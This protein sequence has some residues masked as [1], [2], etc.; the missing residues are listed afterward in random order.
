MVVFSEA[1]P[2]VEGPGWV[3]VHLRFLNDYMYDGSDDER[4]RAERRGGER[5]E[6]QRA[7]RLRTND[8]GERGERDE[9]GNTEGGRRHAEP[10]RTQFKLL[11]IKACG[12]EH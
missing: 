3:R 6:T 9:R 1:V 2:L 10:E 11:A 5:G 7:E 4:Q 12:T 8:R